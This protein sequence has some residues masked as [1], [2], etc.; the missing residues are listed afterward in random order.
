[1]IEAN[2][3]IFSTLKD[4]IDDH[5]KFDRTVDYFGENYIRFIQTNDQEKNGL[6]N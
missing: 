2:R 3:Y 4:F 5:P 6:K 1:M